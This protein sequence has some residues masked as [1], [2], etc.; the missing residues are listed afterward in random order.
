[1]KYKIDK[2]RNVRLSAKSNFESNGSYFDLSL[3]YDI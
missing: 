2:I 3:Q 1:M